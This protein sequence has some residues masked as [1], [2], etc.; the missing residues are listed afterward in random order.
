MNRNSII[1][2]PFFMTFERIII[3]IFIATFFTLMNSFSSF[4]NILDV[5][6]SRADP[7]CC[8]SDDILKMINFVGSI[9]LG[10]DIHA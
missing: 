9:F 2:H 10:A 1:V 6:I 4:M 5:I 8:V 3:F 7:V